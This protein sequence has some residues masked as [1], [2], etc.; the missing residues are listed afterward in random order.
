MKGLAID[1][2]ESREW[3]LAYEV[4]RGTSTPEAAES[5]GVSQCTVYRRYHDPEFMAL[6]KQLRGKMIDRAIGR[7]ADQFAEAADKLVEIMQGDHPARLQLDA[8]KAL[9]SLG[10]DFTLRMQL[11]ELHERIAAIEKGDHAVN[12]LTVEATRRD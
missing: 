2:I 3:R 7:L 4:A 6:V 12:Q 8:A 10:G 9:L 1:D 11:E 5:C